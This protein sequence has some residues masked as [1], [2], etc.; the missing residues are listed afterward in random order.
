MI[1]QYSYNKKRFD[2]KE[3]FQCFY[4]PVKFFGSVC[5]EN[6]ETIIRKSFW[7]S[8]FISDFEKYNKYWFLGL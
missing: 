7:K 3:N 5:R 6:V 8:L 4:I 1:R 2:T